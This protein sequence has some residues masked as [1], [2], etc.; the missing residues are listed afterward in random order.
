[1]QP[2]HFEED[3][4][5]PPTPVKVPERVWDEEKGEYVTNSDFGK[6]PKKPRYIT[7]KR[8]KY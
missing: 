8:L 1:M 3:I 4:L 5:I 2:I 7:K 6:S